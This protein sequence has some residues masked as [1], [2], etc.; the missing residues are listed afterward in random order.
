MNWSV[1]YPIVPSGE[2]VGGDVESGLDAEMTCGSLPSAVT[3]SS[4]GALWSASV[5]DREWKT[6]SPENPP[7]PPLCAWSRLSPVADWVPERSTSLL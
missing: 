7:A 2:T 5:P 3:E 1:E 6:T 4:T